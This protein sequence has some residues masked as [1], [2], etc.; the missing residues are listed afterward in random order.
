MIYFAKFHSSPFILSP[1]PIHILLL[2]HPDMN[3]RFL[4]QELK[5]DDRFKVTDTLMLEEAIN[6]TFDPPPDVI[7]IGLRE[8]EETENPI[9]TLQT[10]N[11]RYSGATLLLLADDFSDASIPDLYEAGARAFLRYDDSPDA[12]LEAVTGVNL[13][14]I[15]LSEEAFEDNLIGDTTNP[16]TEVNVEKFDLTPREQQ[17][18]ELLL[19]C[20]TDQQIAL[21][22]GISPRTSGFHVSNILTKLDIA[23]RGEIFQLLLSESEFDIVT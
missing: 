8:L 6:A 19:Q 3:R 23:S 22:L 2:D 4:N 12:I 7:L 13:G 17:V 16:V 20:C 10:W 14:L 9:Q 18:T 21:T 1:M 5:R 11:D 15:I